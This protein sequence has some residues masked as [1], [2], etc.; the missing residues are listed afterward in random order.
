MT[1]TPDVQASTTLPRRGCLAALGAFAALA[2]GCSATR[3]LDLLVPRDSYRGEP[4][5]AYGPDP[6]HRLDAYLPLQATGPV[7]LVLF[8]YGGSWSSGDRADYRFVG[9]ALA[10][11][12]VA[13]LVADYRLS[14]AVGWREILADCALAAAWAQAQAARLGAERLY[15]MGHSAGAYNAAMLALDPRW[16]APHGLRPAQLAGWIGIAGPYDF[17]PIGSRVV[18]RAFGWPGTPADSQPI[19]HARADAPPALLLAAASDGVV[20]PRRNTLGL[21]QALERAGAPVRAR[22]YEGLNHA[23]AIGALAAPLRR[24]APLREDVLAFTRTGHRAGAA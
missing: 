7:P 8:F 17:L 4:G 21:A 5:L 23:T 6:R 9:E 3:A 19:V 14:P 1:R 15:L 11:A 12:G 18:Q 20:D 22:L 13:T 24:L 16:L 10:S 2:A